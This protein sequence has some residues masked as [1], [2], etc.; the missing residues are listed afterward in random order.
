MSWLTI[1]LIVLF[2]LTGLTWVGYYD[3]LS[4]VFHFDDI[5]FILEN[6][7]IK[8]L[9]GIIKK[10]FEFTNSRRA[11]PI[12]TLYLN[13]VLHS[14]EVQG[15]HIVNICFHALNGF[16]V[17]LLIDQLLSRIYAAPSSKKEDSSIAFSIKFTAISIASIFTVHPLLTASVTYI[18]QRSGEIAT[19]FYVAAFL[20]YL[21]MRKFSPPQKKFWAWMVFTLLCYWFAFK[22]KEMTLTWLLIPVAYEILLR[23]NDWSRLRNVF[24]WA[25]LI[26][27]IFSG[28]MTWYLLNSN[29][30]SGNYFVGFGSKTL[31][32]PWTQVETMSRALVNYWKLLVIPLPQW[33]NIDHD[34]IPSKQAV[35]IWALA[36]LL[37]HIV[38]V[39]VAFFLAR[40]GYVLFALGVA[41]FYITFGP[42]IV[43]PER[44]LLVEYKTYLPSIGLML[45][46]ADFFFWLQKKLGAR[47]YYI[48][49]VGV[50]ILIVSGIAGTWERNAVYATTASAWKDA[51][52]KAPYKARTLHNLGYAYAQ[53]GHLNAGKIYFQK[54]LQMS[55]GFVL[56]RLNLA[57]VYVRSGAYQEGLAEYNMM[58]KLA[59]DFPTG[60]LAG[61]VK[62]AYHEI[63]ETY[64][65]QRKYAEAI[66]YYQKSLQI[67]NHVKS[68][69]ALGKIYLE[70][71]KLEEAKQ[72]LGYV[73]KFYP[74]APDLN[75][76]LGI[77]ALKQKK[78]DE[79]LQWFLRTIEFAPNHPDA[80]NNL[81]I[82]HAMKGNLTASIQAFEKVLQISPNHPEAIKNLKALKKQLSE[83]A[84]AK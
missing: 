38:L 65:K 56:A 25:V 64:A 66:P 59:N 34:F 16:L 17:F 79:A 23:L 31:W 77:I 30:L 12:L 26:L 45:I 70:T 52:N 76:N 49:S 22:S 80:Y 63:G 13:Y 27:T 28:V 35:D 3:S 7:I 9:D 29:Y 46:F 20:S 1:P 83:S 82:V 33:M 11:I 68:H 57:R 51:I 44:D 58:V 53:E 61:L 19:F 41:W 81:G 37:A 14:F 15:Y 73:S 10:M 84:K 42:Y 60:E 40:K 48:S 39:G 43:V 50:L 75:L 69:V 8:D 74:N 67:E 72:H 6:P 54:S 2:W 47:K 62:D 32:G 4:V 24:K 5:P 78:L 18:T 21:Q 36:S 55:P 71:N